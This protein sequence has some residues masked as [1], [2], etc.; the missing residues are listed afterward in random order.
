MNSQDQIIHLILI[1]EQKVI[2]EGLKIL[3]E[4]EADIKIVGSFN[5]GNDAFSQI[6]ELKPT[7]VLISLP[8]SEINGINIVKKI[9]QKSPQTKIIV[10]CNEI[11]AADL[12]EY[13][14]LGVKACLL[15]DIAAG[16]I[17][18]LVSYIAR[19]YNH[20]GDKIFQKTLPELSD[21]VSALQVA[22][23][24]FQDFLNS[25]SSEA[26]FNNKYQLSPLDYG[27][28]FYPQNNTQ[29][30][31]P[32]VNDV[33]L[34]QE[35]SS[36]N[37]GKSSKKNWR[38]GLTSKLALACL[39]IGAIA[40]GMISYLQ[41]A[42]IVIENAVIN[43]KTIAV[44]SPIE[45]TIQEINYLA[46]TNLEAN[47]VFAALK[48]LEDKNFNQTISQLETD[49]SLKQEKI[50][51]GEKYLASLKN[52]LEILPQKSEI[53]INLPQSPQVAT[54]SLDNARE[55]A[56]L[57]QQILNQQ[58]NIN[59]LNKELSNLEYKL[60]QMKAES[61]NQPII[62]LKAPISGAIQAINSREGEL[63]SVGQEVAT[64]IDCQD[65]WVEAIIDSKI[66]AKINLQKNV[67]VQLKDQ[68]YVMAGNV[69]LIESLNEPNR[70]NKSQLSQLT[71]TT[72]NNRIDENGSFSRL[73]INVDFSSSE[74]L[75]Q[76]Y[77]NL[78]LPAKVSINN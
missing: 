18:E 74:L 39:G 73:I 47:Q 37:L 7:I 36:F 41:G 30:F 34:D 44:T 26:S 23:S 1:E 61:L 55:I 68:E 65:L 10:F 16:K 32:L 60:Q 5:N 24:T 70:I 15:K 63:I 69:N 12:V 17:K 6:E 8:L 59:L 40:A 50:N 21:A 11:S 2:R 67:S 62:P 53:P 57:E 4:S 33:P 9:Q 45:G 38:Q 66:A 27:H 20:I 77:C 13:L 75:L 29:F 64:F 14:E 25:S 22:D 43:G 35:I 48:P 58:L 31:L 42:E 72:T 49:I 51:H 52:T 3:L 78:G 56:N 76:D 71:S 28:N 54:I 46:G 19:G